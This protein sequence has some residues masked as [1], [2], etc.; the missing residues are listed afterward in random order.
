VDRGS[1]TVSL[2][3]PRGRL[4]SQTLALRDVFSFDVLPNRTRKNFENLF[5][6]YESKIRHNTLSL[7]SKLDKGR[8]ADIKEEVLA[9]FV[10]KFMN[11]LRNPFSIKKV[12]D[13]VGP[14]LKY[15]PTD[16]DI[17]AQFKAVIAGSKPQEA[18]L[19]LEL[20]ITSDEYRKWLAAL[21]LMLVSHMPNQPNLM[22]HTV[23]SLFEMPSGLPIVFVHQYTHDEPDRVCLLSDRGCSSTLPEPY[24]S[25]HFNLSSR[26]FIS[27]VFASIDVIPNVISMPPQ[28]FEK[29][30]EAYRKSTKAVRVTPFLNHFPA[31]ASYNQ[32]AVSWSHKTVYSSSPTVYGVKTKLDN[33]RNVPKRTFENSTVGNE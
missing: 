3:S 11:F 20:G 30:L 18:Y 27:Y 2:D 8:P 1:F 5:R 25:F 19:R 23:K 22:E 29:M 31:L 7:L 17:L 12:L 14:L 16:P 4:I 33:V 32:S 13:T 6:T 21:F 28:V 24:T 15:E 9:L 10:A 26:A